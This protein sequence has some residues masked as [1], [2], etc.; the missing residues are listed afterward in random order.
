MPRTL[1]IFDIDGTLLHSNKV[2]SRCF[3]AAYQKVFGKKFPSIDW[4]Y[5]PHVTDTTIFDTAIREHFDRPASEEDILK[6]KDCF[7]EFLLE[8]RKVAPHEFDEIPFARRTVEQLLEDD[9]YTL[10]IA[11]GGWQRPAMIKL[12]HIG[13]P[14]DHLHMSFADGKVTRELII[15]ESI[16]LA[17][18]KHMDIGRIVYVGDA[19][20]DVQTTRNMTLPLIG[21]RRKGD[22][23][24]LEK[25][26][27]SHVISDYKDYNGF[28]ELVDQCKVPISMNF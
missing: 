22:N 20:W 14:T 27:A 19:I 26:G 6:Q 16:A 11:T 17:R 2:D 15:E 25:A 1:I 5:F 4:T 24:V 8:K 12:K 7:V 3:A 10:G 23:H 18:A 13:I 21:V 28:L 9:R